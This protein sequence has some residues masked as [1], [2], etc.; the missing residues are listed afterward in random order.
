MHN[1]LELEKKITTRKKHPRFRGQ[2]EKTRLLKHLSYN[3]G[4]FTPCDFQEREN[5][6]GEYFVI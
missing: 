1:A 4:L 3:R 6:V 5:H 2:R